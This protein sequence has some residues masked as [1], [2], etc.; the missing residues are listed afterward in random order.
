MWTLCCSN[1]VHSHQIAIGTDFVFYFYFCF[2]SVTFS[3][4]LFFSLNCH[5][6]CGWLFYQCRRFF[7]DA[8]SP[9]V[10]VCVT[11]MCE[12][13]AQQIQHNDNNCLKCLSWLWLTDFDYFSPFTIW[14]VS[15]AHTL[16]SA[17][18]V[19]HL[20]FLLLLWA[21]SHC[22]QTFITLKTHFNSAHTLLLLLCSITF[23]L[24]FISSP[25]SLHHHQ[26]TIII[27]R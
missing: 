10:C 8:S 26:H 21:H 23:L 9:C 6:I 13:W 12:Q 11:R 24:A 18:S 15:A 17:P 19:W 25:L 14:P 2:L 27:N 22:Q 1:S 7:S 20:T 5:S 16:F 3:T 4:L